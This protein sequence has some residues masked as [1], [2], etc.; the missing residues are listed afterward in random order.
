MPRHGTML[1]KVCEFCG[2]I[3]EVPRKHHHRRFCS[4]P[5]SSRGKL[6]S[7]LAERFFSKVDEGGPVPAHCPQLGPCH[8]FTGSRDGKGYG[9]ISVDGKTQ[10]AHRVAWL[11]HYGEPIPD[12]KQGMHLCDR[13]SCV[14]IS[15]LAVGTRRDNALDSVSKGR[16]ATQ[17]S[18]ERHRRGEEHPN[19]IMTEE[20]VLEIRQLCAEGKLSQVEIAARVGTNKSQVSAIKLRKCWKHL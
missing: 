10:P 8:D 6:Q 5:C 12:D 2:E 3:F 14:R 18:P 20:K 17:T 9:R 13:P 4:R 19:A 11:L 16:H 1:A 15:H 7:T